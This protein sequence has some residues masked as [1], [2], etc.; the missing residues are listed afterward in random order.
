[1]SYSSST[2]TWP[3]CIVSSLVIADPAGDCPPCALV[4]LQCAYMWPRPAYF[5]CASLVQTV[6]SLARDMYEM[7]EPLLWGHNHLLKSVTQK[8]LWRP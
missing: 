6:S 2:Q 8:V 4:C 1:M 5:V 7:E 3:S